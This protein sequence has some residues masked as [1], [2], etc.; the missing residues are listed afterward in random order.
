MRGWNAW[1]GGVCPFDAIIVTAGGFAS[2]LWLEQLNDGGVLLFPQ[3]EGGQ[4]RLVRRRKLGEKV[5]DEFFDACTFVPLLEG[6]N[7]R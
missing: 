6:V 5:T 7:H 1:L 3:G 2:D 4:H